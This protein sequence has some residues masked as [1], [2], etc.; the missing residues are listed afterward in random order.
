MKNEPSLS[1]ITKIS[2]KESNVGYL[3]SIDQAFITKQRIRAKMSYSLCVQLMKSI[4]GV[5]FMGEGV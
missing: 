1:F 3:E 5:P 4:L 2:H